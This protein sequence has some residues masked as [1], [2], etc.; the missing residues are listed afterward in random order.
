MSFKRIDENTWERKEWFDHYLHEAPCSYST[1]V[2]LDITHIQGARLYPALLWFITQT[3]NEQ[4]EFRTAVCADGVGYFSDM[5]PSYTILNPKRKTFSIIW[6]EFSPCYATFLKRY[7]QDVE[8]YASSTQMYPKPGMP[9]N[10]FD[11]SM[12]PWLD[13]SSFSLHLSPEPYTL[14]IF[15]L[16]KATYGEGTRTIPLAIQVHHSVCDGYHVGCFV[17]SLQS[18]LREGKLQ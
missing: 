7:E 18:K 10:T 17:E 3:V 15:T 5:H 1:T 6:T 12:I 13:F 16:G 8:R 14:P 4:K 11:V 9:Q 2:S